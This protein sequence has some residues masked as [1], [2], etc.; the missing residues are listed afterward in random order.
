MEEI[1]YL[2]AGAGVGFWIG[3]F[4]GA[5]ALNTLFKEID[6]AVKDAFKGNKNANN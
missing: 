4:V 1:K 2:V 3:F 5:Y 6:K